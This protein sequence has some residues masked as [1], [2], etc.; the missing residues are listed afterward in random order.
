M[1]QRMVVMNLSEF[2]RSSAALMPSSSLSTEEYR[3]FQMSY[4]AQY[5]FCDVMSRTAAE[6]P[7]CLLNSFAA[8]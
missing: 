6:A 7:F 3:F 2:I 4:V 8:N 5:N 1:P